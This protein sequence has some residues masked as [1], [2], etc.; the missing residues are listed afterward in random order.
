[1]IYTNSLKAF[2]F[3]SPTPTFV[4]ARQWLC[5]KVLSIT[6]STWSSWSGSISLLESYPS[7]NALS[8][9]AKHSGCRLTKHSWAAFYLSSDKSKISWKVVSLRLSGHQPAF[10]YARYLNTMVGGSFSWLEAGNW[11]LLLLCWGQHHHSCPA[12]PPPP[13]CGTAQWQ[14]A[15]LCGNSLFFIPPSYTQYLVTL[16]LLGWWFFQLDKIVRHYC[17]S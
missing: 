5:Y 8:T 6:R 2:G 4:K 17:K 12:S 14:A 7:W 11:L 15:T 10:G 9:W 1:M 13:P 16:F 3:I